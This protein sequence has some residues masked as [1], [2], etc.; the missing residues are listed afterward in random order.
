M[1]KW[2]GTDGIRGVA[3]EPPMTIETATALGRALVGLADASASERPPLVAFARDTR[4]SGPMLAAALSS[5]IAAAGGDALDL[6]VLPTPAVAQLVPELSADFGVVISASHNPFRDNGLKV[7]GRDGFKLDDGAETNI[8][9]RMRSI[10]A[11]GPPAVG[12]RV[13]RLLRSEDA[14]DRYCAHMVEGSFAALRLDGLRVAVDCANGAAFESAPR[15]L[16]MLGADVVVSH[17]SPDGRN[18]NAGCG[19]LHPEVVAAVVRAEGADIGVALDGDADRAILV[20]EHGHVVDG[21]HIMAICALALKAHGRLRGDTLVATQMSN[22]GLELAMKKAGIRM[23]RTAV[24]DRY[25]LEAMREG[26]FVLGGEQSGHVIFLDRSSTG[27]GML[28]ALMVMEEMRQ[29]DVPL[30]ELRAQMRTF[31]Q[32]L[33]SFAVASKPPLDSLPDVVAA[34]ERA[35]SELGAE[36]R[37]VVRYSGTEPKARVMIEGPDQHAIERQAADIAGAIREATG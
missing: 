36:G 22:L 23:L 20:D 37:V 3:N 18:I 29:R 31:P 6:G 2:F 10:L 8:E 30:S 15:L 25:V 9:R 24:G 32:T 33:L 4:A 14:V 1:R 5:G 19:A 27:D 35:E 26:D 34:I 13:G 12:E 21:D 11:A 17:A 7:F 16:R 28:A